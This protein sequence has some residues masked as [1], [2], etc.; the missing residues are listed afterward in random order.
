MSNKDAGL[1]TNA[2]RVVNS[3]ALLDGVTLSYAGEQLVIDGH[4]TDYLL[5]EYTG[6]ANRL[7]RYSQLGKQEKLLASQIIA[8]WERGRLVKS[9]LAGL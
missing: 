8:S 4:V 7:V 2:C 5:V 1:P 3:P 6:K 9:S